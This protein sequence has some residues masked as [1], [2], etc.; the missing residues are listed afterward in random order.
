[1]GQ[2]TELVEGL[3]EIPSKVSVTDSAL[4]ECWS[5]KC[6]TANCDVPS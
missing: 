1:M 5:R 3:N 6:L 4:N 2:Y